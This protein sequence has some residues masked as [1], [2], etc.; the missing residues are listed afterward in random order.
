MWQL[1]VAGLGFGVAGLGF[2][3]AVGRGRSSFW[4]ASMGVVS[5]VL[6]TEDRGRAIS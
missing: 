1:G 4:C 3:V 2:D 6:S 5:D